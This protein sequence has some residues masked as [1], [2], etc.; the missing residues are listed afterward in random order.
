VIEAGDGEDAVHKFHNF[1]AGIDLLLL[2]MD[3]PKKNGKKVYDEIKQI[4]PDIKVLYTSAY[5]SGI[6]MERG[7]IDEDTN[8]LSKPFGAPI[9]LRKIREVLDG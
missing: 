2:D 6:M 8:F 7:I 4:N 1:H 5:P 9:L 3:M